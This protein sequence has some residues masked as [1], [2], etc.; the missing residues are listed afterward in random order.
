MDLGLKHWNWIHCVFGLDWMVVPFLG[1][2]FTDTRVSG[3][4]RCM[5]VHLYTQYFGQKF[6][7]SMYIHMGIEITGSDHVYLSPNKRNRHVGL[8]CLLCLLPHGCHLLPTSEPC[9][10]FFS[11]STSHLLLLR[12]RPPLGEGWLPS[13][14][15]RRQAEERKRREIRRC[16]GSPAADLMEPRRARRQRPRGHAYCCCKSG[17]SGSRVRGRDGG[18][19]LRKHWKHRRPR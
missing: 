10:L 17:D 18:R 2:P 9:R 1:L 12:R 8:A 14:G 4:T 16:G 6:S 19:R 13:A 15:R 7:A 11:L 3:G 5:G